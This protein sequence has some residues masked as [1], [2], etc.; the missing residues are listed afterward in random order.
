MT[1]RQYSNEIHNIKLQIRRYSHRSFFEAAIG[2]LQEKHG[3]P[4]EELRRMPW[5]A[6]FA[7][8]LS[9]LETSGA[10]EVTKEEF[11]RIANK[12]YA[13][14]HIAADAKGTGF[15]LALR[16]MIMQ[17]MWYQRGESLAL[18]SLLR[19]SNFFSKYDGVYEKE[20]TRIAGLSLRNFYR[21]TI[22]LWVMA[23]EN[24]KS[25]VVEINL[26]ELIYRLYPSIG[27]PEL[28][29]YCRL[30]SIHIDNLP[31]F[32]E[33]FRLKDTFR[34]EYFQETPFKNKPIVVIGNSMYIFNS[35]V[36]M[37]GTS[38]LVPSLLKKESKTFK[39]DFGTDFEQYVGKFISESGL[40]FWTEKEIEVYYKKHGLKGKVV[41]Y[42]IFG[43]DGSI[44]LIECKAVEPS[45][46][47]KAS[48]EAD[49][50]RRSLEASFIKAIFQ[51]Q[52]VTHLLSSTEKFKEKKFR[53]LVVTH[54]DHGILDA[55]YLATY[56]DTDL[57]STLTVKHGNLK[58][59]LD[60]IFYLTIGDL[61]Q[62]LI[63]KAEGLFVLADFL[64]ECAEDQRQAHK[65]R[66][67][68][69]QFIG[70]KIPKPSRV[71]ST[72]TSE[73]HQHFEDL[74]ECIESG[75]K[76]WAGGVDRLI[77]VHEL[78]TKSIHLII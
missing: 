54:E 23:I 73:F 5:I 52:E 44:I 76:F 74:K 57:E 39:N 35:I 68:F 22:C 69:N 45:D 27:F 8:K 78:F 58:L 41:D 47:V 6:M 67:T 12:I 17:Q 4:I 28:M 19:Q 13:L 11:L 25:Y 31:A 65:R 32:M 21:I 48:Y 16:S 55:R 36:F 7:V 60:D 24:K 30:T 64:R 3:D 1:T 72:M 38:S 40:E 49:I 18:Q 56:I 26:A 9:L 14:Q 42:L 37:E 75:Q 34:S 53:Q 62:T 10:L 70:E 50:L 29:A 33:G 15:N 46:I 43:E 66:M 77:K 71:S 61:E 63:A 2:Y 59:Q 51:G 20:F